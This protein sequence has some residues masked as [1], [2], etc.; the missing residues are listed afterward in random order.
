MR[1]TI[2]SFRTLIWA[3]HRGPRAA[4]G[5]I[6]TR[7]RVSRRLCFAIVLSFLSI[8]PALAGSRDGVV[9]FQRQDYARALRTFVPLA[10]S[11][12]AVAQAYL[13]YMYAYGYGVPQNYIEAAAWLRAASER[14]Y[15][16]A[17]YMLGLMYD[18][19]Q[20]VPQNYVQAFKWLDLAV[21]GAKGRERDN[22]ARIRDAIGTKLSLEQRTKAQ[23]M[24]LEWRPL[25]VH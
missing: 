12:D 6:Q 13:G 22:W 9:A 10:V 16:P 8:G 2:R 14:G 20:G 25:G 17:Q 11:G 19:G 18:K 21:A 24:A 23:S 15:G 4:R 5:P 1:I 7:S 3:A